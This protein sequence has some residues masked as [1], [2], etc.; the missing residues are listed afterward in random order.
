MIITNQKKDIRAKTLIALALCSLIYLLIL[1]SVKAQLQQESITISPPSLSLTVNPGD[2]KEGTLGL[3]NDSDAT[4]TFAT[5]LFDFIVQDKHGTAEILPRGTI[6]N[7]KYSGSNWLAVYPQTLTLK[8]HERGQLQYFIQVPPDARPGGHYAAIVYQ[9]IVPG[10]S[11]G[12][13]ASIK[14][15][16]ATLV[17]ITVAGVVNENA[18]VTEFSAPKL[19]EYGPVALTTEIQNNS[20]VHIRPIGT[21]IVKDMLR[22]TIDV[23]NLEQQNIF[24][25]NVALDYTNNVGSKWMIGRFSATLMATYGTNNNLPL[26]AVVY[27]WVIPWKVITISILVLIAIILFILILLKRRKNKVPPIKHVLNTNPGLLENHESPTRSIHL[28]KNSEGV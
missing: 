6:T 23:E 26:S 2:K 11:A 4:L 17:Y 3:I 22:R 9:P 16:L 13:G 14:T 7:N 19:S 8:P 27:F 1:P 15:Q 12:S 18:K 28:A 21:I 10:Q 20:D 24:P 25:G 5:S